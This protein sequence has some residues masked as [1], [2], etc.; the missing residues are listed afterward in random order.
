MNQENVSMG[1]TG[2]HRRVASDSNHPKTLGATS[3]II[4]V[5]FPLVAPF[6]A[7]K[8]SLVFQYTATRRKY[9]V[10]TYP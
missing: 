2:P 10:L 4:A 6:V 7:A 5:R 9:F 8:S 1:E 3:K